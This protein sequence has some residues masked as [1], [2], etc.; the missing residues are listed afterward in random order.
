MTAI[1]LRYTLEEFEGLLYNGFDY[2][3]PDEVIEKISDLAIKVGSPDYV[4]TPVFKKREGSFKDEHT[5]AF[6]DNN[7]KK[8]R[9][10]KNS[11]VL[12]DTEWDSISTFQATKIET[13]T[14]ISS[15]IN[16]IRALINKITDKNFIDIN[17][18]IVEMIEKFITENN[19][20]I[21]YNLNDIG[22]TIFDIASSNRY[23]SKIYADLYTDL[24]H[25]FEFVKVTY[26]ENLNKF[27]ELFNNIE[28]VD[29]SDYDK[30]CE[31]NKINEKR[32]SL[33]LF[34]LNLMNNGIIPENKIIEITRNLLAKV[35]EFISLEN[36]KN[37][38]E[39]LIEII[40][41]LYKKQLYENDDGNNYELI[42][43][44]TISE[45]IEE[46]AKSKIKDYV[47]LTKKSIFKFMD[48]IDM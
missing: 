45:I 42:E 46:I 5:A 24:S 22:T 6:K 44:H 11:E 32:R 30:Y 33:A 28:Y 23:Y 34:Y 4:K 36:K 31:I 29:Q 2:K 17:I 38:V 40:A 16:S 21:G 12:D 39:E 27:T 47:S 25:K 48:L 1:T 18:K 43:G 8:K 20:N 15:D 3:V 9:K 26:D 10:N 37:E 14:G 7:I 41:I 19:Q 13:T 35:Y